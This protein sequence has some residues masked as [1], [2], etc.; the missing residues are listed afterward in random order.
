MSRG[1]WI[2]RVDVNDAESYKDYVAANGAAFA[3]YGGRFVVRGGAFEHP[4]GACR[5]R[6][7]VLEVPSYQAALDCWASTEYQA[8]RAKQRGGEPPPS[9][10]LG[11]GVALDDDEVHLGAARGRPW[12]RFGATPTGPA[13]C[14]PATCR[15]G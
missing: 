14:A 4:V 2:A 12:P 3:K 5:A 15:S 6:N 8:A 10:G 1:Y 11:T 7:V 9:L 13:S